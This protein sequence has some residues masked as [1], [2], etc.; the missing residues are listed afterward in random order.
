MFVLGDTEAHQESVYKALWLFPS[1]YISLRTYSSN[2]AHASEK[3]GSVLPAHARAVPRISY[4]VTQ[5]V[6]E[7]RVCQVTQMYNQ[8]VGAPCS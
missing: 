4:I 2:S 6:G 3:P 5:L 1:L 7:H 8:G